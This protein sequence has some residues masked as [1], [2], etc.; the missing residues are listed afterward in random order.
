MVSGR[1]TLE[2]DRK[3]QRPLVGYKNVLKAGE[4]GRQSHFIAPQ[5]QAL[6]N[7][8]SADC[9]MIRS[10]FGEEGSDVRLADGGIPDNQPGF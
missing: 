9:R 5:R 7:R 8:I 2:A 4:T 10:T 3:L 1:M 6:E